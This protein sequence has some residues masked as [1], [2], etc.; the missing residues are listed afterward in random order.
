VLAK[1]AHEV[2]TGAIIFRHDGK[3]YLADAKPATE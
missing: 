1:G 2:T 3:V